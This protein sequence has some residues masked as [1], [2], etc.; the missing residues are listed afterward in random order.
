MGYER[1][2]HSHHRPL[3]SNMKQLSHCIDSYSQET[4]LFRTYYAK[5]AKNENNKSAFM[6]KFRKENEHLKSRGQKPRPQP[7]T[8]RLFPKEA[9]PAR[10]ESVTLT[11]QMSEYCDE[12][13]TSVMQGLVKLWVTQGIHSEKII[14]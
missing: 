8:D 11:A 9:E 13:E 1:L 5:Q 12:I 3:M 2:H 4:G 10:I 7:D 6:D 14:Q